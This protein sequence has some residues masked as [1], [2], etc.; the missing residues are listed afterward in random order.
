MGKP[1]P[2]ERIAAIRRALL[3]AYDAGKRSLPWRGETD[4]YRIWVSEVMLQQTRVETVIPFYRKWLERF[5]TLAELACAEEDDVLR[6]WQGMGYYTRARR[7]HGAAQMLRERNGG[8]VPS[9][10]EALREVPGVGEYTAGA[11]ASIA[12]GQVVPAVDGNVRRVLARVFDLPKPTATELRA[13]AGGLVDPERPGDFNQAL[14]DLG[15][16][17]CTPRSASC[18]S[19]PLDSVCL[20]LER[21]TVK[22][23]PAKRPRKSVP[24]V[25]VAVVVGVWEEGCDGLTRFLVR[26]R[27]DRGLLAGMWEFPGMEME[28]VGEAPRAARRL[29]QELGLTKRGKPIAMDTV[30]HAFSHLRARYW[31]LLIHVTEGGVGGEGRWVTWREM[32]ELPLSAA[33]RK[34]A[35][36]A[37]E[38]VTL[39]P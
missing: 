6:V 8:A 17:V 15:A 34:I 9:S 21:G 29:L 5:P 35:R 2:T 25:E 32:E 26:R 31:P 18:G 10:A 33:Q 14:M 22:E 3:A 20:A 23:R 39:D 1:T 27:P 7:L 13:V 30:R 36:V 37:R 38:L 16:V 11:V 24:E 4:P 28:G 12:F 19:C